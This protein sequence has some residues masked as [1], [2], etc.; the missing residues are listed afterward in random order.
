MTLFHTVPTVPRDIKVSAV[1]PTS[2][3]VTWST[4]A[5]VNGILLQY[6]VY[7]AKKIGGKLE[8]LES[9]EVAAIPGINSYSLTLTDLMAFTLYRVEVS[10]STAV[11][12]GAGTTTFV[13]TDPDSA[14]P[15]RFIVAKVFNFT[16]I[17]LTWGYPEIPRGNITGYTIYHN[18][19]SEGQL[20]V[21]LS[22]LNSMENQTY[23]FVGLMPLTYY[24]FRVAAFAETEIQIHYG[25]PSDPAIAQTES[26]GACKTLRYCVI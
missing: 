7:L 24:E 5:N 14:S 4:P 13:T 15:P 23:T 8:T 21:T 22:V 17:H 1:G 16:V 9:H 25:M 2:I 10:A 18:V 20:N 6:K 26:D 19:T 3:N 11:G 12:E